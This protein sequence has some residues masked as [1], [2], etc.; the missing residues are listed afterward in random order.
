[1]QRNPQRTS[2]LCA[3]HNFQRDPQGRHL[4]LRPVT[5]QELIDYAATLLCSDLLDRPAVKS[6]QDAMSFLRM[7]LCHEERELFGTLFLDHKHRAITFEV[8]FMGTLDFT[9][10]HPREIARRALVLNAASVILAHNHPS[11]D[12]EPSD[13]DLKMTR[14]IRDALALVDVHVLDHVV[15]GHLGNV[16]MADRGLL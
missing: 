14:R 11:G 6:S 10:V 9:A 7:R 8:L 5:R 4:T 1:M 16:S 13:S 3:E 2:T 12:P 15:L